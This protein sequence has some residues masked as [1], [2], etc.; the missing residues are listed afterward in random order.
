MVGVLPLGGRQAVQ[1]ELRHVP[2]PHPGGEVLKE[3]ECGALMIILQVWMF[4]QPKIN[5][6]IE[7]ISK[8]VTDPMS[9][10]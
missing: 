8:N 1:P 6:M 2:G 10:A 7:L 3:V 4:Q 5:S 9:T